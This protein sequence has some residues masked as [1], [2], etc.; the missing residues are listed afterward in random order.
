MQ[1]YRAAAHPRS[2]TREGMRGPVHE[3]LAS[4]AE[5][6][7]CVQESAMSSLLKNLTGRAAKDR[8]LTDEMPSRRR[9]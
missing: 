7:E 4:Q 1:G 8:D 5:P 2:L 9:D 6:K 3:L